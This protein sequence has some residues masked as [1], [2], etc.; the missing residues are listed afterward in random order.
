[1]QINETNYVDKAEVAIKELKQKT[2]NKGKTIPMVTTSKIRNLLAMVSDIYNDVNNNKDEQLSNDIVG[3]INYMKLHFYYEAG[4]E[5][6]VKRLL[7]TANVFDII[8]EIN[9]SRSNYILFSHYM[10]ALVAF[11]R[12]YGG[13]EY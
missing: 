11:H 6:G 10:E 7:E 5:T 9:S 3:R 2:N 8:N 13:K 4:R 12:F 1:M